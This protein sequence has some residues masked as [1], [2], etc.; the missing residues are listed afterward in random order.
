LLNRLF[1]AL[2][3]NHCIPASGTNVAKPRV[4]TIVR[5][6]AF[7]FV[8]PFQAARRVNRRPDRCERC[9]E[10]LANGQDASGS[11]NVWPV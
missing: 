5:H 9:T 1:T 2:R 6:A 10:N 8:L 11:L 4:F 3:Q 7:P